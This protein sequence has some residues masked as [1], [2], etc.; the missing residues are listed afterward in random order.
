MLL[1][2]SCFYGSSH[3][4]SKSKL[5]AKE[6]VSLKSKVKFGYVCLSQFL[7]SQ[8]STLI[9]LRPNFLCSIKATKPFCVEPKHIGRT[10]SITTL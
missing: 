10:M 1:P 6:Q 3:G 8:F 5:L 7:L 2:L 9:N 4:S